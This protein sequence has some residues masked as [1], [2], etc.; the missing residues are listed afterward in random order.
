MKQNPIA[1]AVSMEISRENEKSLTP[2]QELAVHR[3][4]YTRS[5]SRPLRHPFTK[6]L[7]LDEKFDEIIEVL[8]GEEDLNFAEL[9]LLSLSYLSKE[10]ME[11]DGRARQASELALNRAENPAQQASAMAL[12]G[13][14]ETRLGL[15]KEAHKSFE[16]ALRLDPANTDA[17]KRLAALHL[18]ADRPDSVLQM[19]E[20]LLAKGA[21]NARLFAAKTLAEVRKGDL[22]SARKTTDLNALLYRRMLE[23]PT[24]WDSLDSFNAALAEEMINHPCLRYERYG[25][26]SELTWR[27]ENP[28]RADTPLVHLL[29]DKIESA[30]GGIVLEMIEVDH[31]WSKAL[32][33]N[34]LL[35]NWCVITEST[36]FENWHVHQFGWLSG[37]YY[38]RV[39]DSIAKGSEKGGCLAFGLPADLAGDEGSAQFG[40]TIVRPQE[41]LMLA[42][43]SHTYHRTYPHGTGEKRICF[44]FDLRPL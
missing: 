5:R 41:G 28:L 23:P 17:C 21:S 6:L 11:Y 15:T 9:S 7:F 4:A 30:I 16:E 14:A 39:P 38:I 40:E 13:K 29:L 25:S 37:V 12:R 44:A 43:P 31:P 1:P 18:N 10:D 8:E 35:R 32:P 20:Q 27:V 33:Q 26:A 36:G 22:D 19:T 3:A 24:G 42:F 34:A 2:Q